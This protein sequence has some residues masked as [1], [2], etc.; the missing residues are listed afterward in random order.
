MDS[1]AI[2]RAFQTDGRNPLV[3]TCP[4]CGRA[5]VHRAPMNRVRARWRRWRRKSVPCPEPFHRQG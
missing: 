4:R 3:D 5:G 2:A 1:D